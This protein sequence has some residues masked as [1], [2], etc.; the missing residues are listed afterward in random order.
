LHVRSASN[1]CILSDTLSKKEKEKLSAGKQH[2]EG[3]KQLNAISTDLKA[4]TG[5]GLPHDFLKLGSA[6]D[7]DRY[8]AASRPGI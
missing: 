1:V 3:K 4:R 7:S 2:L 6:L 5:L 8:K